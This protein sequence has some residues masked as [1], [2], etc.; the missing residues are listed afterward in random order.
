MWVAVKWSTLRKKA[1]LRLSA[2]FTGKDPNLRKPV[3]FTYQKA[4]TQAKPSNWAFH[5]SKQYAIGRGRNVCDTHQ[6]LL[7]AVSSLCKRTFHVWLISA[8]IVKRNPSEGSVQL[9]MKSVCGVDISIRMTTQCHTHT[10]LSGRKTSDTYEYHVT[11]L[12]HRAALPDREAR[13]PTESW[14]TA[15]GLSHA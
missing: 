5:S 15:A 3:R 11:V 7:S 10:H 12:V 4:P 14:T 9:Q 6:V 1:P 2:C 13:M 8:L